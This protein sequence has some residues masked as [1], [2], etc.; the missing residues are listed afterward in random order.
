MIKFSRSLESVILLRL[1]SALIG[2]VGSIIVSIVILEGHGR[3]EFAIFMAI[4]TIPNLFPFADFG[5]GFRLYSL[6]ISKEATI[7]TENY[8]A[9]VFG[10]I[11]R[12][13][14]FLSS[15]F[16]LSFGLVSLLLPNYLKNSLGYQYTQVPGH[17]FFWSVAIMWISVPFSL[18]SRVLESESKIGQIVII[19]TIIPILGIAAVLFAYKLQIVPTYIAILSP[20]ISYCIS[21]ILCFIVAKS[22]IGINLKRKYRL[23]QFW[24]SLNGVGIWY[25]IL[26][27]NSVLIYQLPRN[28]LTHFG[29]YESASTYSL[30][31]VLILPL[32]AFL[33]LFSAW[34]T[35][36]VQLYTNRSSQNR[37]L[38]KQIVKACSFSSLIILLF[39]ILS[40]LFRFLHYYRFDLEIFLEIFLI[41]ISATFWIIP[42]RILATVHFMQRFAMLSTLV[43]IIVFFLL[44]NLRSEDLFMTVFVSIFLFHFALALYLLLYLKRKSGVLRLNDHLGV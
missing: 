35:P 14:S 18:G 33:Q 16:L 42:M 29:F 25:V 36:I 11:F 1:I 39:Y 34:S 41:T 31:L 26:T 2:F 40:H 32:M 15:F 17:I 23:L 12:L 4:S 20:V 5:L 28:R 37:F 10:A 24:S 13:S 27:T 8:R 43:S 22:V 30:L 44:D 6:L 21:A 9:E 19:Q 7:K 3:K 38:I